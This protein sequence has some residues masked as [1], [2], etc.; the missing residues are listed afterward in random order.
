MCK[1]YNIVDNEKII[2]LYIMTKIREEDKNKECV[3]T[4]TQIIL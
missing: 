2:V 3:D 1:Y 4:I